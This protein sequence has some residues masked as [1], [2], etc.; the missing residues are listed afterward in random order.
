MSQYT[1]TSY[2]NSTFAEGGTP[3]CRGVYESLAMAIEHAEELVDQSLKEH[4][5]VA[6][7]AA[8]LMTYFS[9]YGSEV[10][11]IKGEPAVNFDPY[12]Y[13]KARAATYFPTQQ[14]KPVPQRS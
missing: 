14:M 4:L 7:D 1:I 9:I 2:D 6:Q 12:A 11:Y 10:P 13:A 3:V 5:A 8:D